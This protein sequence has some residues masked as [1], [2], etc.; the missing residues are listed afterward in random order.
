MVPVILNR[1]LVLEEAQRTPDGA[2]GSILTGWVPLGTLWAEV[3]ARTGRSAEGEA[4]SLSRTAYRIVVRAA[5]QG[6][7]SRPRPGQRFRLGDRL[8]RIL[9]VAESD[10]A[11]CYLTC[12]AEEEVAL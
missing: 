2:G 4:V 1:K 12:F 11:G 3:T 9:S 8:F 10:A 5:P 6:A 7:P